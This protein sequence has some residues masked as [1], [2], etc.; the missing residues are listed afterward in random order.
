VTWTIGAVQIAPTTTPPIPQPP[1]TTFKIGD[2]VSVVNGPANIRA[3]AGGALLGQ[4]ANGI[5]GTVVGGPIVAPIANSA[6]TTIYSWWNVNFDSGI[7]G[8]IGE[9]TLTLAPI[10][11]PIPAPTK[12]E[13]SVLGV[14]RTSG[15]I[16]QPL[17]YKSKNKNEVITV[18]AK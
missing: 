17:S 14:V 9:A 10:S 7:D 11:T 2:R 6:D 3:T 13:I 1:S 16:G 5:V 8:W 15:P 4:Q 12:L 18:V